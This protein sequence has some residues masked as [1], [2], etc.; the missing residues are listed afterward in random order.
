MRLAYVC[1]DPGVPVFG[2]KGCSVHV[3][4]IVRSFARAGTFV[5]LFAARVGGDTPAGLEGVRV[6]RL[7]SADAANIADTAARERAALAANDSLRAALERHAGFDV[8][9]ERYSLWSAAGMRY[10]K[11][12]SIPGLL[13]V[14]APLVDEQ[15][16]YRSLHDRAAA[17]SM[18]A[19]IF[20]DASAIAAVSE[21]LAA[22][23]A[24][25]HTLPRAP[26]VIPNG[27]DVQRFRPDVVP[28]RGDRD[29]FTVGFVGTLKPWHGIGTLVDAF[30]AFARRHPEARLL[31]VG[32]GPGLDE[33]RVTLAARGLDA[34]SHLTG[35]VDPAE[36]P[37]LL[38]SMTVAT[39]P[40]PNETGFYF[41]PL[42]LFEYMAAGLPIVASRV[43]QIAT[44]IEDGA[45]GVLCPAGDAGSLAEAF[46][47]LSADS[48]L[49]TRLG[50]AARSQAVRKHSWDS[51]GR[52]LFRIAGL[53]AAVRVPEV[54]A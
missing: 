10:A 6:H 48:R 41:S 25:D 5:D 42:K 18:A 50:Q 27:V 33:L 20:N 45:S 51:V 9:Y 23:I 19:R 35:A 17:V 44:I 8:V 26:H 7:S 53:D 54:H 2:R 13:E 32:D 49:R 38:T 24:R 36:V 16:R 12:R 30:Q 21:E 43:G 40:Y 52:A 1:A 4:E 31:V 46:E 14:N 37:A 29:A 3:Q 34:V 39:A 15:A 28:I 47:R 11:D 22:S